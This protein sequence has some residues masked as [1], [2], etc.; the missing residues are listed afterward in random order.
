MIRGKKRSYASSREN[1]YQGATVRLR[2]LLAL[3]FVGIV[4]FGLH[5]F[6]GFKEGAIKGYFA[7]HRPPPAPVEV[8]SA[9]RVDVP[10]SLAAIGTITA[11]QQ[12]NVTTQIAAKCSRFIS[13]PDNT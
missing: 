9:R 1:L 13:C 2:V 6:V 8:A 11:D 10:Q 12:V 5:W 4:G 3:L 7:T